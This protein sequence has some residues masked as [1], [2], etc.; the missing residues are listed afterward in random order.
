MMDDEDILVL[1]L[2]AKFAQGGD[3]PFQFH[4][5]I[6]KENAFLAIGILVDVI[7]I[8]HVNGGKV[9]VL[10]FRMQQQEMLECEADPGLARGKDGC[11]H[12]SRCPAGQP[13]LREGIIAKRRRQ[14]DPSRGHP[15]E[16]LDPLHQAKELDTAVT[17]HEIVHFIDDDIL[18]IAKK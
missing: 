4:L 6:R 3:D 5:R 1:S 12:R 10:H 8:F 14:P 2:L 13:L 18:E 16:A 11:A 17:S 7:K 9:P 15:C